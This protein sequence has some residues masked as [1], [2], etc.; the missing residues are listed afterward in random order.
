MVDE[1]DDAKGDENAEADREEV[2]LR[3]FPGFS[4]HYRRNKELFRRYSNKKGFDIKYGDWL[5]PTC[6]S[7]FVNII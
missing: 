2:F 1:E 7:M 3:K 4:S 6:C 5:P